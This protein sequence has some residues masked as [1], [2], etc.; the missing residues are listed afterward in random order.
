MFLPLLLVI[1]EEL[2]LTYAAYTSNYI[3]GSQ[4]CRGIYQTNESV[5]LFIRNI[6]ARK[7]YHIGFMCCVCVCVCL[8]VFVCVCV[9]VCVCMNYV[10]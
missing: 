4:T 1:F 3:L 7:M 2:S 6:V 9:C 8:C 5:K 10:C